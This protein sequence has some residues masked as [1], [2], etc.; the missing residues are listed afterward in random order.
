MA[1][2]P[3]L[4]RA[5]FPEN[6][7]DARGTVAR[8]IPYLKANICPFC[9]G[10]LI[11]DVQEE[12]VFTFCDTCNEFDVSVHMDIESKDVVLAYS[13][14]SGPEGFVEPDILHSL[15]SVLVRRD[16]GAIR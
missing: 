7:V 10:K 13:S 6:G 11:V 5:A 14:L 3:A 9:H 8:L 16:Y 12:S 15:E 1:G 2:L 4:P